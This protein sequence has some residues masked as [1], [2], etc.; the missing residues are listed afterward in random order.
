MATLSGN[1]Y[2]VERAKRNTEPSTMKDVTLD[3]GK[4]RYLADSY[5]IPS[6]DQ[7]GT[8]AVINLFKI[9]KGA[10]VLEM[11]FTAPSDGTSGQYAI[12]W[13]ASEEEDENGTALEA[14]DAD[15]FYAGTAADTGAG[16]LARLAMAATVA[17]YRKKFAA[18]VQVQLD[19]VEATTASD[20]DTLL[21]EA[22]I[23]VS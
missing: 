3:Y 9:P 10:R 13:A 22:Y 19:C 5:T 21:L 6:G 17:G 14:A 2:G 8:S 18:E 1:L 4:L 16:A 7:V 12:G 20:G 11:F 23:V 15:G